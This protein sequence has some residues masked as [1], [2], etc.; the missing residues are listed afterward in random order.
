M[1]DLK[2]SEEIKKMQEGGRILRKVVGDLRKNIKVG[3]STLEINNQAEKIIK[4]FSG[5]SSFKKV[6]DYQWSTCLSINEE[7]VHSPP[8]KR[9]LVNGD[10][11]TLDIGV[12]FKGFHTDFADSFVVGESHDEKIRKFLQVGKDTLYKAIKKLK[13]G[14]HLG[15]VSKI[16]EEEIQSHGYFVIKQLTGHGIGRSLHE[17]PY[18]LGYL[19]RPVDQTQL[20]RPG[21]TVAIEVI[22]S[23]GT[24]KMIHEDNDSWIIKTG[25]GSL[26]AC[27]EHSLAV[28]DQDTVILT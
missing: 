3:I 25:D 24:E 12:Y 11:L 8:S 23:M 19:D 28:T 26:S 5:Q 9:I 22:Y 15:D 21:L 6:K 1:I 16:I 17:D 27:F 14:N 2:T 18:V 13:N 4:K 20:I 7:I 10:I